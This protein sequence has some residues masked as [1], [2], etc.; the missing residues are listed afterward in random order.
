MA[1]STVPRLISTVARVQPGFHPGYG[2]IF[3]EYDVPADYKQLIASSTAPN[4]PEPKVLMSD[5]VR[6]VVT[7]ARG[8][9]NGV[10]D[11]YAK[12]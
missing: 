2:A 7:T 8:D 11:I 1:A 9:A 12:R 6:A 4:F 5:S 3:I 10:L